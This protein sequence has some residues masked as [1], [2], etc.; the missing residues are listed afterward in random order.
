[1]KNRSGLIDFLYT[2]FLA[3]IL[4][5]SCATTSPIKRNAADL[6]PENQELKGWLKDGKVIQCTN[7]AELTRQINGGAPFYI[8]RGAKEV[9]FQDYKIADSDVII[10]LEIYKMGKKSQAE[11]LFNDV[12]VEQPESLSNIGEKAR[13]AGNLIGVY[14]IDFSKDVFYSRITITE[15]NNTSKNELEKFAILISDKIH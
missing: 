6:V 11:K 5:S 15:K 3:V 2:S 1:M 14:S 13:M 4:L 9:I 8:E 12:F 10:T 7:L